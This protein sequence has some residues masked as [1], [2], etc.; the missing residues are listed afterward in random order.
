MLFRPGQEVEYLIEREGRQMRRSVRIAMDPLHGV[1]YDGIGVAT[2]IIVRAVLEGSPAA[3]GGLEVGDRIA[4]IDGHAPASMES[5]IEYIQQRAGQELL[6][7]IVRGDR[8]LEIPVV[9]ERVEEGRGQI[10]VSL[11]YPGRIVRYPPGA[12]LMR[13][14][15]R[16]GENV[17]LLL[18]TVS[19]LVRM[20]VGVGVLSGPLEIA[21]ITQD[22]A[23]H[24]WRPLFGL[25]AFI[26]I[27]LGIFNLLPIPVLDGG[28]ILILL[29]ES[30]IRRDL[31]PQVKERVLQ[32]GFVVLLTFAVTVIALDLRKAFVTRPQQAPVSAPESAE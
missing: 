15:G 2:S 11:G 23:Q 24:G 1:G 29:V 10:G 9:P 7:E 13:A 20:E 3:V 19:S 5:L 4:G 16:A 21:R 8:R 28:N 30:S 17:R 14:L 31:A 12:A 27:N 22:Q 32:L 26:S 6:F 18:R 25:L